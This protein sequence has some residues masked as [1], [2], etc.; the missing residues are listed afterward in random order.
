MVHNQP[1]LGGCRLESVKKEEDTTV[2]NFQKLARPCWQEPYEYLL[3]YIFESLIK[4][5]GIHLSSGS[6]IQYPRDPGKLTIMADFGSLDK[7]KSNT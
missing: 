3:G 1:G 7:A 5:P 4:W 6:Q 2:V